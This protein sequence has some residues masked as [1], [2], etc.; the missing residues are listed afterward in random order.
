MIHRQN[1]PVDPLLSSLSDKNEKSKLNFRRGRDRAREKQR[2]KEC[3]DE[4]RKII[5]CPL[6][7][8]YPPK[9]GI[10]KILKC[11]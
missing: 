2:E 7:W 5:S 3:D 1:Q 11:T 10:Q 6:T 4:K 8:F 9:I